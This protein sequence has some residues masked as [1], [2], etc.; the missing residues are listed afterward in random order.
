MLEGCVSSALSRH[1]EK[2]STAT[3]NGIVLLPSVDSG[4]LR[5]YDWDRDLFS[6]FSIPLKYTHSVIQNPVSKNQII[7]LEQ[8]GPSMVLF[9]LATKEVKQRFHYAGEFLFYGHGAITADGKNLVCTEARSVN[10]MPFDGIL[11]IRNAETLEKIGQIPSFGLNPHDICF[12]D[13]DVLV[14][15]NQGQLSGEASNVS[16]ISFKN[17]SLIQQ[18]TLIDGHGRLSHLIAISDH[19]VFATTTRIQPIDPARKAE[20]LEKIKREGAPSPMR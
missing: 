13:D 4:T 2:I 18:A 3:S 1:A 7:L 11:T 17:K 19:E 10:G 16:F 6:E 8:Y 5:I 15:A 20:I 14:V 12:L 9:D